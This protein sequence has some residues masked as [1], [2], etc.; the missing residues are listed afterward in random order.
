MLY[1]VVSVRVKTGKLQEFLELFKS[2]A[3]KVKQEKGCIQYVSMVDSDVGLPIQ[4]L[5]K[6]VV[7]ILET[8]E[9][10][11]ALRN[12]FA[13][14]HMAAYFKKEKDLIEG[15]SLKMLQEA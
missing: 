11:E 7:T 4:V 8:W 13:S 3:I 2:N 5:D 1:G 14:P 12:H 10:I 15:V 9:S 6:N